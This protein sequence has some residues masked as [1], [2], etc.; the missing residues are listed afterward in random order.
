[1]DI[2]HRKV[3]KVL[4]I[5]DAD[6]NP[7]SNE[8]VHVSLKNHEF[9]FGCG[10]FE[11][12]PFVNMPDDG[13]PWKK[14]VTE[15]MDKWLDVFNYGTL[16]FYW[17]NYEREEGKTDE[18]L[19]LPTAKFLQSKGVKV[20]GHPL[21]WHTVC[22]NW[23]MQYDNATILKKQLE[24]I[25]REVGTYKGVIDMWDVI[26]EV[27]IMP[28]FDKYDN[29]I[30]RICKEKGRVG[31]IKQV[32][33]EA[34]SINPGATL[35][36]NDFNTSIS[37][38]ILI[39]GCLSAGVPISAIG[40][41]SHQHQGYWGKEKIEEV[42]E[43]YSH[44]GLPIHFTENTILSG[45][46]VPEY[47][48]DLND[49]QVEEWPSTP[50]GEERQCKELEEMYRMLFAHPLVEAITTW[51]FRDGAW[52]KAPSGIIRKDGTVK[53]AYDML[54]NLIHKEW[55]TDETLTTDEN[56]FVRLDAFKGEY[57]IEAKGKN[58]DALFS[59][60][61]EQQIII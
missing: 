9:L 15:G 13:N 23:L 2:S 44:F 38:E 26:N 31:L 1:M 43:R 57:I 21:C 22:A 14:L 56:G 11:A 58:T 50:E 3:S 46:L 39:D 61:G 28:I 55:S 10:A 52:L 19:L 34:H 42:L 60:D 40:I 4:K 53:P 17:G 27:V 25:D 29:A 49:W 20:K 54:K 12:I 37:Y 8:K 36:L 24:R 51:D 16:P 6:N 59:D 41:Q 18:H 7:I 32:F 30:T 35:L 48:E 45:S 47:I 5:T 33:D